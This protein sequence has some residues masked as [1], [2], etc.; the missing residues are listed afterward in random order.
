MIAPALA[1]PVLALS[2]AASPNVQVRADPRITV[3][4][5][6]ANLQNVIRLLAEKARI[7]VVLADDVKGSVTLTLR[8]VPV[9]EAL[10]VLLRL[11]G[12]GTEQVGSIVRVAPLDRLRME[13]EERSRLAELEKLNK[14]L[15]TTFIPVNYARAE[16]LLPHV[17]ATL[18]ERGRASVDSRTNTIIVQD[19]E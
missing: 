4:V 6:D 17:K 19:I 18:S 5:Q 3:D 12:L 1:L 10:D 7:N 13:A 14:P 16:E 9:S 2:L 11:K 8:N 15:K